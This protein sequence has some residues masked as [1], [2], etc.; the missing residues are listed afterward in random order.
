VERGVKR[1]P[2]VGAAI[3][4]ADLWNCSRKFGKLQALDLVFDLHYTVG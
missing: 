1:Y 2:M 4:I 3:C